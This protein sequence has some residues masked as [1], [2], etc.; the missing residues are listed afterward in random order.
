LT[1]AAAAAVALGIGIQNFPEGAAVSLPARR[2]LGKGKAFLFG[3][4]SGSVELVAGAIGFIT[5]SVISSVLPYLMS[6]AAGA[7][8]FASVDDVIP[9]ALEENRLTTS[10]GT[11]LG[12]IIMAALDVIF[13]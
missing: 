12:F 6:F 10:I 7:M 4:A 2:T 3:T 1:V 8:I 11:A 9:D 5:A 13:G